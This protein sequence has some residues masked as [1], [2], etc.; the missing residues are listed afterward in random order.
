M[1]LKNKFYIK[2]KESFGNL[3]LY[4]FANCIQ[5]AIGLV[6]NPVTATFLTHKDFSIIGYFSSF[7]L[8]FFPFIGFSFFSYYAK[9]YFSMNENER[10]VTLSTLIIAQAVL[11]LFTTTLFLV[12]LKVYF[13]I[14][15]IEFD[16]FP[17]ALFTLGSIYF[18]NFYTFILLN[19]RLGKKAKEYFNINVAFILV[20]ASSTLLF[21][22]YLKNGASGILGA[23]FLSSFL[24]GIYA[25]YKQ[26]DNFKFRFP[27]VS[28][29]LRFCWPLMFSALLTYFFN[30]FDRL[31]LE[32]V[33]DIHSFG[34][35]NVGAKIAGFF[36]I[37][38]TSIDATFEPDF[39]SAVYS[40]NYKKLFHIVLLTNILI[41]IPVVIFIVSGDF[42]VGLLTNF[43]YTDA[44]NY[45]RI[46]VLSNFT[47]SIS[48]SLST[49]IIA[50]GFTKLALLEKSIGTMFTIILTVL[51]VRNY[52]FIGA[53][54]AQVLCYIIMSI[55]SL[56]FLFALVKMKKVPIT[57]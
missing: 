27:I 9:N 7:N 48:F 33:H 26:I 40:K 34:L 53:A 21:V 43:K 38:T 41:L 29:A 51:L 6:M 12:A 45:A 3:S 20:N 10:K 4:F 24:I 36:L 46:M 15:S 18:S 28:K 49:I 50:F 13:N 1:R 2:Y 42:I 44:A 11:G 16:F 25:F 57:R 32:R 39:Y 14:N 52:S 55:V 5:A 37:F 19:F 31:L 54:W 56:M 47:R 17:Y 30:G 23:S 35:Y 8:F 22:V